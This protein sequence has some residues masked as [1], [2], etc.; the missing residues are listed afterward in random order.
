MLLINKF[1]TTGRNKKTPPESGA[2]NRVKNEPSSRYPWA[3]GDSYWRV[4]EGESEA[5]PETQPQEWAKQPLPVSRRRL[6]L[7]SRDGE[8]E[9]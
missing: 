6:V 9:R 5:I 4:V 7:T 2:K 3:V 8:S 1:K